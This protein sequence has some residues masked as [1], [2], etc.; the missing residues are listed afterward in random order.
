MLRDS[1][2]GSKKYIYVYIIDSVDV[3][4]DVESLKHLPHCMEECHASLH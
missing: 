4:T 3:G 1:R 2:R